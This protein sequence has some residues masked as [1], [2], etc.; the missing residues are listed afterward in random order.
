M[1]FFRFLVDCLRGL[2]PSARADAP[3][4]AT[5]QHADVISYRDDVPNSAYVAG[6]FVLSIITV[7]AWAVVSF[8]QHRPAKPDLFIVLGMWGLIIFLGWMHLG[9]V[10]RYPEM[11]YIW[12][13][14]Q[15][16][17]I[18][19]RCFVPLQRITTIKPIRRGTGY[20]TQIVGIKLGYIGAN[21]LETVRIHN[22]RASTNMGTVYKDLRERAV[23]AGA[24]LYTLDY[25]IP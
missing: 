7:V 12:C 24:T 15:T 9:Q 16:V 19:Q 8:M 2:Y 1:G 18:E 23:A 11:P 13:D 25:F 6:V 22:P 20:G 3:D 14:A 17:S 21:G 4:P 5:A 10:G